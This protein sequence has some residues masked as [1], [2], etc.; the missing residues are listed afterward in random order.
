MESS[1][2]KNRSSGKRKISSQDKR[3]YLTWNLE[4]ECVLADVL[5]DQ[6]NLGNKDNVKSHFKLWRTWY[7]IVS[8]ILSQSEF[9]WDSIKYMITVE[10]E[11]AWNEYVKSHEEAKR[12]QF[13]VIPNWD[14]IVDLCAKDKATG[15]KAENALDVDDIMSKEANEEEVMHSVSIDLEGSS[16]AT[17]QNIHLS[18]SGE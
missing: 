8:D 7:G 14:G 11:I 15:L 13:K 6:R 4:M 5:R 9:D 3:S 18:K 17:R 2:V 12:F 16:S 1:N 10:N